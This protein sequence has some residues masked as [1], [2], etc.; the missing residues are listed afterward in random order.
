MQAAAR[1]WQPGCAPGHAGSSAWGAG[2]ARL[3]YD[4]SLLNTKTFAKASRPQK[5]QL[6]RCW[7]PH[8][9][10]VLSCLGDRQTA[11]GVTS[12]CSPQSATAAGAV[13]TQQAEGEWW[14][15][16]DRLEA[17]QPGA[18]GQQLIG[19]I[20]KQI[21]NNKVENKPYRSQLQTSLPGTQKLRCW[22]LLTPHTEEQQEPL[23][24]LCRKDLLL[25]LE[26]G[27]ALASL[28][29]LY[30]AWVAQVGP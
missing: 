5:R 30:S 6:R 24:Q 27:S 1:V 9:K 12:L 11:A 21:P 13:D 17:D 10:L 7:E 29:C 19:G 23:H 3:R 26:R 22:E 16:Q 20:G 8:Y 14:L 4:P 28:H 2:E 15:Q 25:P 18:L